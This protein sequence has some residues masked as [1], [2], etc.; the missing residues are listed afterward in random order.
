VTS[1]WF[2]PGAAGPQ[3]PAG[4]RRGR[5]GGL[6]HG[7]DLHVPADPR[8]FGD[9]REQRYR[10]V[11]FPGN[12]ARAPG[13]PEITDRGWRELVTTAMHRAQTH[14]TNHMPAR[15]PPDGPDI[16]QQRE[17]AAGLDPESGGG[18]HH[19][20]LCSAVFENFVSPVGWTVIPARC[21]SPGRPVA[22][23]WSGLGTG[24]A[25]AGWKRARYRREPLGLSTLK[26]YQQRAHD[27]T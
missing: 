16:P 14:L 9:G 2:G 10:D 11:H 22:G 13:T 3:H 19:I 17:V 24:Q 6:R 18:R 7:N 5:A 1:S 8:H 27:R 21:T 25:E 12:S 23:W 15:L 26:N 20:P 4:G